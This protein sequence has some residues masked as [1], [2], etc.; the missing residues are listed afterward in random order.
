MPEKRKRTKKRITK[1]VK[2]II[3]SKKTKKKSQKVI[4][5]TKKPKKKTKRTRRPKQEYSLT[6]MI[7]EYEATE[8]I[9]KSATEMM[10]LLTHEDLNRRMLGV[11]A[12]YK[13]IVD[14]KDQDIPKL[15]EQEVNL[16]AVLRV[17]EEKEEM[18]VIVIKLINSLLSLPSLPLKSQ[19]YQIFKPQILKSLQDE[20]TPIV[21]YAFNSIDKLYKFKG[22]LG[23]TQAEDVESLIWEI[24]ELSSEGREDPAHIIA[25]QYKTFNGLLDYVPRENWASFA[26]DWILF[27][28]DILQ[29]GKLKN[30][31]NLE[32]EQWLMELAQKPVLSSILEDRKKSR[33]IMFRATDGGAIFYLLYLFQHLKKEIVSLGLRRQL[34]KEV[35]TIPESALYAD[36]LFLTLQQLLSC[37]C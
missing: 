12:I 23:E 16:Q 34:W 27:T 21:C 14:E 26:S 30:Y 10:G 20:E 24:L 17:L 1:K 29:M 32:Y 37:G 15:L 13:K 3:K 5:E 36:Y 22:V 7:M 35:A 33:E 6:T 31:R 9:Q 2:K 4:K 11:F 19:I 18:R 28:A 8:M 25:T